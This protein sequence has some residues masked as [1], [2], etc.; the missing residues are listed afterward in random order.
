MN[1]LGKLRAALREPPAEELVLDPA[2]IMAAGRRIRRR[3][4]MASASGLVAVAAAVVLVVTA[5]GQLR[6]EGPV[7]APAAALQTA[8]PVVSPP[9]SPSSPATTDAPRPPFGAVIPTG[10]Y[11][12]LGERVFYAVEIDDPQVLPDVHFGLMAGHRSA[13]GQLTGGMLNNEFRGSDRSP[14]FHAVD[15]G[16]LSEGQF[17]PVFGYFVGPAEEITTTVH[18]KTMLARQATWSKDSQ[19]VIFWFS[20]ADVPSSSVLTPL[21][22]YGKGGVRLTR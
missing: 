12:P 2:R 18:G 3:R 4:R 20:Q 13:G 5:A 1:D 17:L 15:G 11:D 19:V 9:P 6:Q 8:S 16:E 7:Q 14:G 10:L 21:V 22:A